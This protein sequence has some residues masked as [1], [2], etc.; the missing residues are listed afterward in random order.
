MAYMHVQRLSWFVI[1]LLMACPVLFAQEK[2]QAQPTTEPVATPFGPRIFRPTGELPVVAR[3]NDAKITRVDLGQVCLNRHGREVLETVI[4]RMLIVQRCTAAKIVITEEEVAAE[5]EAVAKKFN[6]SVK[7]WLKMLRQE[8]DITRDRYANDIIWPTLALRKLASDALVV[9]PE[10]VRQAYETRYG[11]SVSVR[12]IL[13]K[14]EALAQEVHGKAVADPKNFGRLAINHSIDDQSRAAGGMIPPVRMHVGY[15]EIEQN[16]FALQPGQISPLFTIGDK[17]KR[18]VI[19]MCEKRNPSLYDRVPFDQVAAALEGGI[20]ETKLRRAGP[21]VFQQLQAESKITVVLGSNDQALLAQHPDAAAIVNGEVIT[22]EHLAEECIIRYGKTILEDLVARK[23]IE[24][25]AEEGKI[26][27]TKA[28]LDE[29]L[30][31]TAKQYG[32]E[33]AEG[34]ADVGG[35]LAKVTKEQGITA[36]QYV[37]WMIWPTVVLKKL[38][39]NSVHVDDQDLRRSF[40]AN[41]GPRVRVRAIVFDDQRRAREVWEM[42]Q[43]DLS[44]GKFEELARQYSSDP[45]SASLGGEVPPIHKHSGRPLLESEAFRLRPGEMSS[46]L[47]VENRYVILYCLGQTEP[48][49]VEFDRVRPLLFADVFEKKLRLAMSQRYEQIRETA[50]I[51]NYLANEFYRPQDPNSPQPQGPLPA[52]GLPQLGRQP[53]GPPLR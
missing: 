32:F 29:E 8:R 33:N 27:I 14:E 34:V 44:Q 5:I 37:D 6:S 25:A 21:D 10:E 28:D 52:Q 26:E 12:M 1:G 22:L 43:K 51:D 53:G 31:H 48:L 41:Y 42:A 18:Y 24:T 3:V 50:W 20:R 19:L 30:V 11:E 38:S 46:I 15:K 39:Y 45:T 2:P 47:Q 49:Q 4:N 16:A 35:W 13:L 9:R 36:D 17:E 23:L 40:E 7:D